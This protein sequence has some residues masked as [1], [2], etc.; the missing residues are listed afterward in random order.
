[1]L[2]RMTAFSLACAIPMCFAQIQVTG[3]N[4]KRMSDLLDQAESLPIEFRADLTLQALPHA[5]LKP[6]RVRRLLDD[7][8]DMAKS[9]HDEYRIKDAIQI[10]D[11]LAQERG[12]ASAQNLDALSIRT[13]VIE[14][15]FK[16]NPSHALDLAEQ[17]RIHLPHSDCD[18]DTVYDV[19]SYYKTLQTISGSTL[20]RAQAQQVRSLQ[21]NTIAQ[22][23]NASELVPAGEMLLAS[24]T[25]ES[26]FDVLLD[27]YTRS[28][29][30]LVA[31]DRELRG[32][33]K[34]GELSNV[35]GLLIAKADKTGGSPMLLAKAYR[36]FLVRALTSKEC[37]LR[38]TNRLVETQRFNMILE[39][40]HLSAI[41]SLSEGDLA[42]HAKEGSSKHENIPE[43]PEFERPTRSLGAAHEKEFS[44]EAG[45]QQENGSLFTDAEMK[46]YLDLLAHVDGRTTECGLCKFIAE[47]QLYFLLIDELP[48]RLNPDTPI[49]ACIR[50]LSGSS[51][52]EDDPQ[53]W[54][55]RFKGVINLN[56]SVTENDANRLIN[57]EKSGMQLNAFPHPGFQQI[58]RSMRSSNNRVVQAYAHAEQVLHPDY[59]MPF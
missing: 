33:E 2:K 3:S 34:E 52:Q 13:R 29:S 36:D 32:I 42:A 16:V 35:V 53:Q 54:L 48:K 45:S 11:A 43:Y 4:A 6:I 22:M 56:R 10:P 25:P 46:N 8:F 19:S 18:Q 31:G 5:E 39:R 40:Y 47:A 41:R 1:L 55:Y 17:L 37:T 24:S 59:E 30:T 50:W 7:L 28:M 57:L 9:A 27:Q 12:L 49:E 14:L 21:L 15:M 23:S 26:Q 44:G 58:E 38:P 51:I 20:S